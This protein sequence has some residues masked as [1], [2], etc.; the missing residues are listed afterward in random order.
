MRRDMNRRTLVGQ[1]SAALDARKL[2]W[3]GT[4]GDDVDS[5]TELA[6]F[7][8]AFSIIARYDRRHS[9]EAYSLEELSGVR[10][11]LDD[12]EIDEEPDREAMAGF[13]RHAL[14][15]L[16]GRT[17]VFTY[18]PSVFVS[19]LCFA[20]R[21]RAH[22]L[23]MF[24]DHQ[25]AFEHKPWVESALRD[26]GVPSIPW[27]YVADED[28]LETLRFL[29]DGPVMLRRSRTSGGTGL[30]RVD[31]SRELAS[32]WP[33][34]AEAYVSVAP[35]IDDG[36]PINVGAV[37]WRDG[38]TVHPASVQLIGI[39]GCTARPF[40]YCGNDFG[41]ITDLDPVILQAIERRTVEIGGWLRSH[42]YIGA[43]GV[44]F[45]VKD[46]D[47]LFTEVNPRF[48]GSTHLSCQ[49]SVE[50]DES[51]ILLDHLAA[52][53][54]LSAPPSRT[55]ADHSRTGDHAHLV[56][57]W[58]GDEPAAINGA[59]LAARFARTR[60]LLRSD[61]LVSPRL[62]TMPGGTIGRLTVRDRI[63]HSGFELEE[64]WADAAQGWVGGE[65]DGTPADSGRRGGP[66]RGDMLDA[67][68]DVRV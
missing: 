3:F 7:T 20:R 51:C 53:L 34:E 12:Y 37:V 48:Q 45:L 23:G 25:A 32:V 49:I 50:M 41:A 6:E 61:L 36:L 42:G 39:A 14:R 13:R 46:G 30:T 5:V 66:V 68:E 56:V 44:D 27:T 2:V 16:S 63:T 8:A 26:V 67:G 9:I 59:A 64:P 29:E 17:A 1:I 21:D 43:F 15:V 4:R 40:G 52:T 38:V 47:A 19:A 11:D 28:Q 60:G 31:D 65:H 10:V 33:R 18:R 57:H 54:G 35:F 55:L 58:T 62:T 24:K 22:Y